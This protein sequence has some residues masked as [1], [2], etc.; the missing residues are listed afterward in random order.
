MSAECAVPSEVVLGI[1]RRLRT[2]SDASNF[3]FEDE[4][5]DLPSF[6]TEDQLYIPE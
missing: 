3:L 1:F 6:E 5:V 2:G 4:G